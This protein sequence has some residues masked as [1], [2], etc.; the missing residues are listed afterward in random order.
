[1]EWL[2][3]GEV[4]ERVSCFS[5][6]KKFRQW[7]HISGIDIWKISNVIFYSN[8]NI[9]GVKFGSVAVLGGSVKG[10]V[11][12]ILNE[13]NFERKKSDIVKETIEKLKFEF[14]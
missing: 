11:E 12:R 10:M 13:A 6:K 2:E 3:W 4:L 1:M 5:R 9:N 14:F 7:F 8:E